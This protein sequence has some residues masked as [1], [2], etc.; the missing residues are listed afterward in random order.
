MRRITLKSIIFFSALL[1]ILTVVLYVHANKEISLESE[2]IPNEIG[3]FRLGDKAPFRPGEKIQH[4]YHRIPPSKFYVYVWSP[5][6]EYECVYEDCGKNG[7]IVASVRGWLSGAGTFYEESVP[8]VNSSKVK[9]LILVADKNSRIVGVYPN[10]DMPDIPDILAKHKDLVDFDMLEGVKE[11]DGLQ[12]G[13]QLPFN[14]D[15]FI[16]QQFKEDVT[17]PKFY[18]I[19]V[20]ETVSDEHYCPYLECG[21]TLDTIYHLGGWFVDFDHKNPEIIK[22]LGLDPS[23][24]AKGEIT[25]VVL[26]DENKKIVSIHPNKDMRDIY[27]VLSQHP[28]LA[29]FTN[30]PWR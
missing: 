25:L 7:E 26:A 11:L 10:K 13:S 5:N 20:H 9:S 30:F 16:D 3:E 17:D 27:T 12:L 22:K 14:P 19:V 28:D 23:Q 21:S 2:E 24:V 4:I 1:L 15:N 29:R 6:I 18:I 8:L